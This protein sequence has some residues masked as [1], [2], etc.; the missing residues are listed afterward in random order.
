MKIEF[1][2]LKSSFSSDVSRIENSIASISKDVQSHDSR[3]QLC[4]SQISDLIQRVDNVGSQI[5][6]VVSTNSLNK[7]FSDNLHELEERLTRQFNCIIY[8]MSELNNVNTSNSHEDDKQCILQLIS[9]ICL[10]LTAVDNTIIKRLGSP[11]QTLL[12]SRPVKVIF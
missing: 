11:S 7:I 12:V 4:E 1:Q 5:S 9:I 10:Q 2:N 8:G 3:V 6:E